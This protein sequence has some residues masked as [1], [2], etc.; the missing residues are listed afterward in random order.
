MDK[1]IKGT[2]I[3]DMDGTL[4][5]TECIYQKYWLQAAT[6]L[7]YSLTA[8]DMLDFRSLGHSFALE[9]M[10][11][12]TGNPDDYDRI[13]N[14]H[15]QLMDPIMETLEIPLKPTIHEAMKLLKDNGFRL[16][17]ATATNVEKTEAY[18]SRAG[19]REYFDEIICAVM[20]K[21]GKPAPDIYQYACERMGV[22]PAKAFA[23]EDAPNGVRSA[24]SAGCRVIMIPDLSE[25]DEELNGKIVC[26]A[27]NL[28]E[29]AEF[30]IKN[31]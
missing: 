29:A 3:F 2:A 30:M 20:V 12:K 22:E 21:N 19:L 16:A 8:E 5:D 10:K 18:L 15:M 4:I 27:D 17:I 9:K 24:Y 31:N 14:Y 28:L 26:R 13:R 11:E 23:V 6:E 1:E 25:P 7:G